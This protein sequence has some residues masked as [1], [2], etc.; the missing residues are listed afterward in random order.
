M[1]LAM[2]AKKKS[3]TARPGALREAL[4]PPPVIGAGIQTR[5]FISYRRQDTASACAH[6]YD[7]L[8]Q[9]F[10]KHKIF[11]DLVSIEAGENFPAVIDQAIR[12]TS[13]LLALIG[14]RWLKVRS[15]QGRRRIDDPQ[16]P[17][18]LEIE[19]ALR[20]RVTVIPV[21]VD[22]AKMPKR[23]ELPESL[24][25]LP[26]LNIYEIPWV[27]GVKKL[28]GR[29]HKIEK[30]RA[31]DEAAQRAEL[32]RLDLTRS[33]FRLPTAKET[34]SN[35]IVAMERS[36]ASRGHRVSLDE[37]DLNASLEIVGGHPLEQGFLL[38]DL[39]YVID[40]IGVK[41]KRS[42]DRY[43]ARSYRLR[44]FEEIPG[45]LQLG[46]PILVGVMVYESWFKEPA[47]KTGV[48]SLEKFD[49][50]QGGVMAV[51]LAWDPA[52]ANLKLLTP[53]PTWGRKGIATM[54]RAVAERILDV[55]SMR[56]IEPA[57]MSHPSSTLSAKAIHKLATKV[58]QSN[59]D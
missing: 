30:K 36:L 35:V 22:G 21:L 3:A 13:V 29:I 39:A 4:V 46:R 27:E 56:S 9:R 15:P 38:G 58:A 42:K 16:D 59:R 10:G 33:A 51:L 1:T 54:T 24:A 31:Q 52:K 57:L 45:Q 2:A 53:W 20:H 48:I 49:K 5:I 7:S 41:A 23:E 8:A 44:S 55:D 37:A 28:G 12:N 11:R 19:A 34:S 18:R 47:S 25:K 40:N 14:P 17:V 6:L 43:V 26:D 32:E 50:L